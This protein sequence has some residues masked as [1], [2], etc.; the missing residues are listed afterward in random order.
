[1]SAIEPSMASVGVDVIAHA[2]LST[3]SPSVSHNAVFARFDVARRTDRE[4]RP[5]M[6]F[7]ECEL[8]SEIIP[9]VEFRRRMVVALGE[10]RLPI[11]TGELRTTG[12]QGIWSSYAISSMENWRVPWPALVAYVD[13]RPAVQ[14]DVTQRLVTLDGIARYAN[15]D[16]LIANVSELRPYYGASDARRSSLHLIMWDYRARFRTVS[17]T[18]L[19]IKVDVEA[20]QPDMYVVSGDV[21]TTE[22][23]LSVQQAVGSGSEGPFE[24][25]VN[26]KPQAFSLALAEKGTGDVVDEY[27][28]ETEDKPGAGARLVRVLDGSADSR[29]EV[30]D[31][32]S[33]ESAPAETGRFG[34]WIVT[35]QSVGIGGQGTVQLVLHGATFERGA[36]KIRGGKFGLTKIGGQRFSREME[37][38]KSIRHPFVLRVL[39]AQEGSEPYLVTE[40]VPLGTLNDNRE[41]FVG[42]LRRCLTLIRCIALALRAT[43]KANIGAHRDVKPANILLRTLEHPLLADF[44]VA[45]FI[46][47]TPLTTDPPNPASFWFSPP[48]VDHKVAPTA[49]F[50]IFSLGAVFHWAYT[51][52]YDQ[53]KPYKWWEPIE[54]ERSLK[55]A[56][57]PVPE[58]VRRMVTL[59]LSR[60]PKE[61]Q[62]SIDA[63]LLEIDAVIAEL[64]GPIERHERT[65]ACG[66]GVFETVGK[67]HI[68]R[69]TEIEIW[70]TTSPN[71]VIAASSIADQVERCTSC[72]TIRLRS[73]RAK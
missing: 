70:S 52:L 50:D 21:I 7:R 20:S 37:A 55:L 31:D 12:L 60:E 73:T 43:Y 14:I 35:G 51:G 34:P 67:L 47:K 8:V 71:S 56:I 36:L 63:L 49:A 16:E 28:A 72:G 4:V 45:H 65:C 46:D 26:S 33:R 18:P 30:H 61:R 53:D 41:A 40:F 10:G 6:R 3:D 44:G 11:G 23:R 2:I 17:R 22:G 68:G 15:I 27:T 62:Q 9:A 58:V 59:M 66:H 13:L 32:P 42:D 64:F 1:M 69:G 25:A 19:G 38:F 39:D 29:D 54:I 5:P 24:F 48:E 57:P